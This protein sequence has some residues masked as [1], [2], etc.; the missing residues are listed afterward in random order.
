MPLQLTCVP[1]QVLEQ[2]PALHTCPLPHADPAEPMPF[3]PQ[4]RV[5][6]QCCR[7]LVGSTQAPLQLIW[8]PGQE[9][10]QVPATH[11]APFWQVVPADPASPTPQP[12][13]A[14]QC[15]GS[16]VG[17]T[18]LRWQFTRFEGQVTTHAPP[19]HTRP[20]AHA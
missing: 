5:A 10:E 17:S 20:A 7:S 12:A 6:P 2:L 3:C 13:V 15:D 1:A 18:Q 8:A 11:T 16:V 4:P 9:T 14:P 19:E